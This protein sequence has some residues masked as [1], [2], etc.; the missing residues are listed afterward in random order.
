MKKVLVAGATGYLGKYV[1]QEF[2]KQGYWVRALTRNFEKLADIREFI[3]EI[4]IGEV[5]KPD[6]L[7]SICKDIDVVFSS[8]GITKGWSFL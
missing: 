3:D 5:T 6:S 4:F 2:K 7:L 8:I 1:V